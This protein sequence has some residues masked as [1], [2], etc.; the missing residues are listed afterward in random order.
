MRRLSIALVAVACAATAGAWRIAAAET[1]R[2]RHL[3]SVYFDDKGIGLNLPESIACGA[4][5][6]FVVGD[7]G[8]DRLLRFTYREKTVA[9]GSEIKVPQLAAPAKLQVSSKGEILALDGVQRRIVRIGSD[10]QYKDAIAVAGAPPPGTVVVK[11]FALDGSDAVYVL[12]TFSARVLVFG[13]DGQFQKVLP[14]P[15]GVGFASRVAVDAGGSVLLLDS[16]GRRLFSA[17][18]DETS[19]SPLGSDLR[20]YLATLPTALAA[21]RGLILILEGPAGQ[22]SAVGADGTFLSRQLGAGW[23]DGALNYP[24]QLCVNDKDEVFVADRDNSRVQIFQL[25]R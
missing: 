7:T 4:G 19:F 23:R 21:T 1:A 12:D 17:A 15:D 25:I 10:G 14:V 3:A 13:P 9:G 5:G 18:K 24:S 20:E 2:F 22:L 8:N 6:Q 16:L 11:D